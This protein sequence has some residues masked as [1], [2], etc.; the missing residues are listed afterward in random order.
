ME[1]NKEYAFVRGFN[2]HGDWG[3]NGITEWLNFD[4]KRY[5]M[6]IDIA[7]KRFPGMNTVRIWLSF[8]AYLADK[9]KYLQTVRM[10]SEILTEAGLYIIPV[11][12][13][14]WISTPSFG[15]FT[16][17]SISEAHIPAYE[18]CARDTARVLQNANILMH[19]ISNEP[20]NNTLDNQA[21]FDKVTNF[22]ERMIRTVR[23]EDARRITVGTQGYPKP[24]NRDICD[25]DRL[26]PFVDVFSLHP[27]NIKGVP[28]G[29]FEKQFLAVVDYVEKYKKPYII[30]ESVWGA[31][32]AEGRKQYLDSEFAT[33]AKHDVGFLVHALFTCPVADLAPM[34]V[35]GFVNGLYMAFLDEEFHIRKHHDIF[36]RYS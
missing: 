5:K 29:E 18:R 1:Y 9:N 7:N 19:D 15:G 12:F 11:Y 6:M 31:P 10:A 4:A 14:G 34:E 23:E 21:A 33:Y 22:L 25:I 16:V 8:D 35:H 20:Y 13:N 28:T 24:N 26:A 30:T 27:Y 36:N 32:D 2:V 3:S 17:E